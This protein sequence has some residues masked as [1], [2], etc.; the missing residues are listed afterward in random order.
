MHAGAWWIRNARHRVDPTNNRI[1]VCDAPRYVSDRTPI[2]VSGEVAPQ[3]PHAIGDSQ[4]GSGN[5]SPDEPWNLIFLDDPRYRHRS[6]EQ[7]AVPGKAGT[8]K[9]VARGRS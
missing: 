7:S 2:A 5:I 4:G 9:N 8:G 6:P 1:S 3:A